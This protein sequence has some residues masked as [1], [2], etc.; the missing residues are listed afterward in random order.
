M[1]VLTSYFCPI[2]V[3][4]N[5]SVRL[6]SFI[7]NK[8]VRQ[9]MVPMVQF[10]KTYLSP[11]Q[12]ELNMTAN[13][14]TIRN[15]ISTTWT[16]SQSKMDMIRTLREQPGGVIIVTEVTKRIS[17][18]GEQVHTYIDTCIHACMPAWREMQ[19]LYIF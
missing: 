3:C 15:G 9:D 13:E 4:F 11:T 8:A 16:I 19:I 18:Y 5:Q 6:M 7:L 17:E 14:H 12:T 1:N 2:A 10:D